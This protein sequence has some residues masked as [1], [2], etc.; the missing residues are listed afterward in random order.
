MP[1]FASQFSK[2][3]SHVLWETDKK[4]LDLI[5]FLSNASMMMLI[6][7]FL[8][9]YH[10]RMMR[11]ICC[12]LMLQ[13][14]CIMGCQKDPGTVI[15]EL[16]PPRLTS[17]F[18]VSSNG[19]DV[20][21]RV[22]D[23]KTYELHV[24]NLQSG[25]DRILRKGLAVL[26]GG[27]FS[28]D[29]RY[30]AIFEEQEKRGWFKLLVFNSKPPG[31][32]IF[33]SAGKSGVPDMKWSANSNHIAFFEEGESSR[34]PILVS[35]KTVTEKRLPQIQ[36]FSRHVLALSPDATQI[37]FSSNP[38]R[39][40]VF[41]LVNG[42]ESQVM[43]PEGLKVYKIF[44]FL[45]KGGYVVV[46]RRG[47]NR[48]QTLFTIDTAQ[49]WR[50][51]RL[52]HIGEIESISAYSPRLLAVTYRRNLRVKLSVM[53][54]AS[55]RPESQ[56]QGM[57][58]PVGWASH[59]QRLFY[60]WESHRSTPSLRQ[61]TIAT[62]KRRGISVSNLDFKTYPIR[63][64]TH[65]FGL[66]NGRPV[67]GVLFLPQ[68]PNIPRGAVI[69]LHGANPTAVKDQWLPEIASFNA[70][71]WIVVG[72]NYAGSSHYGESHERLG[73][74]VTM[75]DLAD[76]MHVTEKFLERRFAVPIERTIFIG[77]SAGAGIALHTGFLMTQGLYGI[78]DLSGPSFYYTS[79]IIK[80]ARVNW[81][82][83]FVGE[84]DTKL[85][86]K[87]STINSLIEIE[88]SPSPELAV[89]VLKDE[90]HIFYRQKSW[91]ILV[92]QVY[93]KLSQDGL[94]DAECV[95]EFNKTIEMHAIQ[96]N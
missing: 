17:I 8:G 82:H 85:S 13:S 75:D 27:R 51:R 78:V 5:Q 21:F 26:T 67:Y 91:K 94:V 39:L 14:L 73:E 36:P 38:E 50:K 16:F 48:K 89:T 58:F 47:K 3:F 88:S 93:D 12:I 66:S 96:Q 52:L 92:G 4:S 1:S 74:K 86:S 59:G 55:V 54:G 33:E 40:A 83:A 9:S 31:E 49:Q 80:K 64:E 20:A 53:N 42:S 63:F 24:L 57:A 62:N 95:S 84:H 34:H 2:S 29:G 32:I 28:P 41:N 37:L 6:E 90:G 87:V 69:Y 35:L 56:E 81:V 60:T 72:L 11:L 46:G 7:S 22:V 68:C 44:S 71:G 18:S 61:V 70:M 10:G 77:F 30:F 76:E 25:K 43:L 19:N 45:R 65:T 15:Q 23:D 79:E